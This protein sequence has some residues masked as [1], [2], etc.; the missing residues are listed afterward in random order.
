MDRLLL[1]LSRIYPV[2]VEMAKEL[3]GLSTEEA[4]ILIESAK[5]YVF[6]KTLPGA[7]ITLHDEMRKMVNELVWPLIDKTDERKRRDSKIAAAIFERRVNNRA[8]NQQNEEDVVPSTQYSEEWQRIEQE[9]LIE[10]WVE[11]ALYADP[12]SGFDILTKAWNGARKGKDYIFAARI[13]EIGSHFPDRFTVDQRFDYELMSARQA[14]DIGIVGD[15]IITLKKLAK[16][17]AKEPSK[18]SSI[19]NVL[20]IAERKFGNIKDAARYLSMNLEIIKDTNSSG[21]PYV[22]NQLGYTYRLMGNLQK[23]ESTYNYALKLA[24]E[25]EEHDMDLIV[26]QS[27]LY[28]WTSKE[29]RHSRKLL[30]TGSGYLE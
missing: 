3:L 29:I 17:H 10:Q 19:Y 2:D 25:A 20:G 4:K 8:Y 7:K 23:A 5:K 27:W 9:V 22:A 14:N 6:V 30:F 16:L 1:V 21:V 28:I 15:S 11:H 12:V 13:R 26:K 18:L 24:V